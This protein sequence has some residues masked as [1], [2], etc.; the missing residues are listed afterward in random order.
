MTD[1]DGLPLEN[2]IQALTSQLDRAQ[3]TMA[4]KARAG[5]P[6]TFAVKDL[7]LDL[8][9]HV[10]MSGSVV[11][12]R[13]AGPGDRDSSILHLSVT[14]ITKPMIEEN[15]PAL[16]QDAG[17][18]I[19]EALGDQMTPDEIRRLEWT[20]IRS[21]SQL[22]Q[23]QRQTGAEEIGRMSS[24]PVDRL[25]LALA[26]A[27]APH[28]S[29]IS[30][31]RE[32]AG[33]GGGEPLL[34]VHGFNLVDGDDPEVRIGDDHAVVVSATE[35]ELLVRPV[36]PTAAGVLEVRTG[37]GMATAAAFELELARDESSNG[38]GR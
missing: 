28:V 33:A 20:G 27:A 3:Q 24:L 36:A 34:R 19:Q 14:T 32:S 22:R 29:R 35:N 6:L 23:V 10:A 37:P 16:D 18:S 1:D 38:G 26:K 25:R 21:V 17:P 15:T 30:R 11:R 2:F 8:R 9:T 4:L 12:I 5:L 13:P 31:A 7:T